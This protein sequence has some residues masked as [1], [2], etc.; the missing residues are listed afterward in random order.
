M[1]LIGRIIASPYWATIYY[2]STPT[3]DRRKPHFLPGITNG[4][5]HNTLCTRYIL[6]AKKRGN[7]SPESTCD[8]SRKAQRH[9][10]IGWSLCR[11]PSPANFPSYPWVRVGRKM[12]YPCACPVTHLTPGSPGQEDLCPTRQKG[13][14]LLRL[15]LQN[16]PV[17]FVRCVGESGFL[18]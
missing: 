14:L 9:C 12:A 13:P 18:R 3:T 10:E 17:R 5:P 6:A 16:I 11:S 2:N 15:L 8:Q 7:H 4:T 1:N